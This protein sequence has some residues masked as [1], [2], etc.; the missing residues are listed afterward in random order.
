MSLYDKAG[1]AHCGAA[2]GSG[3]KVPESSTSATRSSQFGAV[4]A[5]ATSAADTSATANGGWASAGGGGRGISTGGSKVW[6]SAAEQS[7]T[8]DNGMVLGGRSRG[9]PSRP[10]M[11][12]SPPWPGRVASSTRREMPRSG[13]PPSPADTVP[14]DPTG[15][16]SPMP[17]SRLGGEVGLSGKLS[18]ISAPGR[19]SVGCCPTNERKAVTDVT[20]ATLGGEGRRYRPESQH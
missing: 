13:N 20:V 1:R 8:R 2:V 19:S 12:R 10:R 14:L 16:T 9:G 17:G 6:A 3:T 18:P 7:R 4:P 5:S 15:C 11:S